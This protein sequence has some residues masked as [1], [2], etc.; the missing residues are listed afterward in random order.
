[1]LLRDHSPGYISSYE[2]VRRAQAQSR[3]ALAAVLPTLNAQGSYVHQFSTESIAVAGLSF[4]SP[5][6]DTFAIGG[7]L[8]WNV[9]DPRGG[10]HVSFR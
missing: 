7:S 8:Q 5:P 4:V 3:I 1:M 10:R 9:L 2:S 6:P